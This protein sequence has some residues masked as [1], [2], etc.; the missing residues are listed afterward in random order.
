VQAY[1]RHKVSAERALELL[2]GTLEAAE[3]PVEEQVPLESM[4]SQLDLE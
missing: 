3:L 4:L 1:K 2:R